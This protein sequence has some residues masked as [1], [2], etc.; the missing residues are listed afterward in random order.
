MRRNKQIVAEV[1]RLLGIYIWEGRQQVLRAAKHEY[2]NLHV[3]RGASGSR[4]P[5]S[6]HAN[7][8][9]RHD[10]MTGVTIAIGVIGL[11]AFALGLGALIVGLVDDW[12]KWVK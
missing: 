3:A 1:Q 7:Q 12:R 10:G 2:D 6:F 5:T 4:W 11:I 8:E 9:R